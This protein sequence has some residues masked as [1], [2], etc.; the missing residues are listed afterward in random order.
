MKQNPFSFYDFL[1]Y[2]IPGSTFLYILNFI[3]DIN[4][5]SFLDE[6][7]DSSIKYEILIS[8]PMIIFSYIIGHALSLLSSFF[9]EKF[10]TY[11]YS[12]PSRFLFIK[13]HHFWLLSEKEKNHKATS[14]INRL[15]VSIFL[16]PIS[17]ILTILKYIGI[18]LFNQAK[19]LP[20]NLGDIVFNKCIEILTKNLRI[21]KKLIT[22]QKDIDGLGDDYFRIIYHFIFENSEKHSSKLQNYVALYG[23]CRNVSFIFVVSFWLSLYF[24]TVEKGYHYIYLTVVFSILSFLFFTGFVKF[25]RRYTLEA[26]MGVT[27]FNKY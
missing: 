3:F 12:Y 1:G 19:T 10:S 27:V 6:Y 8:I 4:I 7:T 2:L 17:I 9:I 18:S 11:F 14:V 25:Y 16:L 21:P 22:C 24:F 20:E 13:N 23:F 26:L 5:L 15:L